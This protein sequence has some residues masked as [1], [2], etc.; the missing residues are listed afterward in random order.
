[1]A[2]ATYEATTKHPH[3]LHPA[4]H[5]FQRAQLLLLLLCKP[6]HT[7]QLAHDLLCT[8]LAFRLMLCHPA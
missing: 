3:T 2:A 6:K 5:S 4:L 7:A 1:M 8:Q